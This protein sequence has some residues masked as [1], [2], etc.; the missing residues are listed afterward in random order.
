M[1][2]IF[3]SF[4][5]DD[6]DMIDL[7]RMQAKNKKFPFMFRDYSVKEPFKYGWGGEVRGLIHQ[8]SIVIV[9]IG[10]N[11]H[12]SDAVNWEIGEAHRQGK[13]VIGARLHRKK[14][15]KI[16]YTM[17]EYDKITYW[18]THYI[19]DILRKQ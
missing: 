4:D 6:E 2:N 5:V 16:P 3:I 10:K 7:L 17:N 19:A 12:K 14:K 13:I 18:D 1:R 11:T 8:S 9:A 15:H